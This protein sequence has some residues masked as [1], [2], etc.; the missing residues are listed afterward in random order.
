[1]SKTITIDL[2]T[3]E[4]ISRVF[5]PV[6]PKKMRNAHPDV[7]KAIDVFRAAIESQNK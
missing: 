5:L 7:L 1:M 4:L 6:N 3:A 2:E